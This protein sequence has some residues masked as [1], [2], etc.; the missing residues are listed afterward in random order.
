MNCARL[1]VLLGLLLLSACASHIRDWREAEYGGLPFEELW[2]SSEDA[3]TRGMGFRLDAGETDRGKRILVSRWRVRHHGFK[4]SERVRMRVEFLPGEE[5]EKATLVR[6][7][8]ERE[9]VDDPAKRLDPGEDDWSAGG[10]DQ[11]A[12]QIFDYQL[13]SRIAMRK[14]EDL[15]SPS[16]MRP[17]DPMNELPGK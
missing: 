2:V 1:T 10:Q 11:R 3:M 13:R 4:P 9:I 7:Y 15:P 17:D 8:A 14:G 12:E 16:G 6:Y 5:D